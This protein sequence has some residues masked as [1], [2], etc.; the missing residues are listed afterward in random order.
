MNA[1]VC[2]PL[3]LVTHHV[4]ATQDTA[5]LQQQLSDALGEVTRLRD[6]HVWHR[7]FQQAY[8]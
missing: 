5:R 6:Q 2:W 3:W 1:Y 8:P 7:L 4:A